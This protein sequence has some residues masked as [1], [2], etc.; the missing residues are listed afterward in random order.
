MP[1]QIVIH[2]KQAAITPLWQK[3]PFF[4][5]FP[6]RLGPAI[7]MLCIVLAS[8]LASLALGSFG[9]IF[10]GF[11]AYLGLRYAFNV[12]ELFSNGRFESESPDHTLW[13]PEKRPAKFGLV[14]ALFLVIAVGL[15]NL[16]VDA[17]IAG[18]KNVQAQLLERYQKEQA[19]LQAEQ[20]REQKAFNQRFGL[21]ETSPAPQETPAPED[22]LEAESELPAAAETEAGASDPQQQWNDSLARAEILQHYRPELSDP[23]WF[24]LQPFWYW[25]LL[26]AL[27][28]LLPSAVIVIALEDRFFKSLNPGNM[29]FLLKAMGSAYF[30]LWALFLLIAGARHAVMTAGGD[31]PV[32]LRFPLEM[33]VA[34]YLGLVLFSM[35]G[36]ALYQYH[37]EL[38]LEVAV[39]FDSHRQA[40]GAEAIARA[41]SATAALRQSAPADPL[42]RKLQGLIAEGKLQEAIAEVQDFM[43]YDRFDPKLN[44]RLHELYALA[45]D[46]AQTL[47]H[48]QKWLVALCR[49]E[50]GR[51]A[52]AALRKLQA[53]DPDFSIADGD[54][55]LPIA[56]AAL[57][58]RDFALALKLVN[59]FD[60]RFPRHKDTAAVLFIAAQL[61]SEYLRKQEQAVKLLQ[62]LLRHFPDTPVAGEARTYLSVLE[63]IAAA[64]N[65]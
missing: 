43:R 11:L 19:S 2:E 28:L 17:R 10:K 47:A 32:A 23:L 7:F 41:G 58:G 26:L 4:F 24:S 34:T 44:T 57:Q 13:G 25:L 54:S 21:P 53:L 40:G 15:G 56:Q 65:A 31:W 33:G 20:A 29:I 8:A 12:L 22:L 39:D 55:I 30:A 3:L 38:G 62:M 14:I 52:L 45:G 1:E 16:L 60:K 46:T 9:L 37:Q 49:G 5:R 48:G 35:I 6:F 63:K 61:A 42:E 36:Y 59:G 18:D 64:Q 50:Q 27:S 51:E